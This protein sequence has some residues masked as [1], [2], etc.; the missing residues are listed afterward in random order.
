MRRSGLVL[1]SMMDMVP[2]RRGSSNDVGS[3]KTCVLRRRGVS[4]VG[5][6]VRRKK[7]NARIKHPKRKRN[8]QIGM[9]EFKRDL[10]LSRTCRPARFFVVRRFW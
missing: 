8:R 3:A 1:L 6:A 10:D 5:R 7:R 2:S 4:I 9:V